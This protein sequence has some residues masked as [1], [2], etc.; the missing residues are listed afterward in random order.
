MGRP[1]T[2][3][4]WQENAMIEQCSIAPQDIPKLRSLLRRSENGAIQEDQIKYLGHRHIIA[5]L[6]KAWLSILIAAV[7]GILMLLAL[8]FKHNG[9]YGFTSIHT[10]D[11]PGHLIRFVA[12]YVIPLFF[13]G[14]FVISALATLL[15]SLSWRYEYIMI[16][17]RAL[18]I[19]FLPPKGLPMKEDVNRLDLIRI[20]DTGFTQTWLQRY[21]KYGTVKVVFAVS[22]E[23][24]KPFA[25]ML[26]M[27]APR[28]FLDIL[29]SMRFSLQSGQNF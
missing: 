13:F 20:Q 26:Y 8:G 18:A 16:T 14:T 12:W 4:P 21:L 10:T 15:Q 9:Y 7:A 27:P 22:A 28:E 3:N 19:A 11:Q 24:D 5:V 6:Q 1:V 23:Q 29:D 2:L 17:N 25:T